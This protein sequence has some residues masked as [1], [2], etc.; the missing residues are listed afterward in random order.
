MAPEPVS[1]TARDRLDE[2]AVLIPRG[3][4]ADWTPQML[5]Q[6]CGMYLRMHVALGFTGRAAACGYLREHGLR[7]GEST[8]RTWYDLYARCSVSDT[9]MSDRVTYADLCKWT[10][11]VRR[12]YHVEGESVAEI[13]EDY[14]KFFATLA[15]GFKGITFKVVA[16]FLERNPVRVAKTWQELLVL[17][18]NGVEDRPLVELKAS[19]HETSGARAGS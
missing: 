7:V 11:D 4:E 16:R 8:V 3:S 19:C 14:R 9:D 10:R 17:P 6:H 1:D 12:R 5:E 13:V 15:G 18:S 2:S